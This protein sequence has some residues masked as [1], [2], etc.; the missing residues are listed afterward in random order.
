MGRKKDSNAFE[1]EGIVR[2]VWSHNIDVDYD[3]E[4]Y[5]ANFYVLIQNSEGELFQTVLIKEFKSKDKGGRLEGD[6]AVESA[7]STYL[8]QLGQAIKEGARV[9]VTVRDTGTHFYEVLS[10]YKILEDPKK[11]SKD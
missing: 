10:Q 6:D 9:K 1:L 4:F 5:R 2:S 11:V 3:G 7:A 8:Y